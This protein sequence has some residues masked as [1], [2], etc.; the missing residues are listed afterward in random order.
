MIV[1]KFGGTSIKNKDAI[2]NIPSIVKSRG[3]GQLVVV[4]ALRG[5][6][7]LLISLA[8]KLKLNLNSDIY[9]EVA[10]FHNV[11]LELVS[12]I[13][14]DLSIASELKKSL[15]DLIEAIIQIGHLSEN[16]FNRLL[17]QGELASSIILNKFLE[18]HG[19][20]S[21]IVEIDDLLEFEN[22]SYR[23][24]NEISSNRI[25]ITQ[26][27]F[28]KKENEII[29][30]GRGGSD[31]SASIFGS[32]LNAQEIQIWTDVDGLMSADPRI[33]KDARVID[34]ISFENMNDMARYGAKVLH[35][36]TIKPAIKS[37]I[38]VRILNTF[39]PENSGT[40]I[41]NELEEN[42][43]R[44]V[45]LKQDLLLC[46]VKN[47]SD[48]NTIEKLSYEINKLSKFNLNVFEFFGNDNSFEALID[49]EINLELIDLFSEAEFEQS[50]VI[51]IIGKNPTK[52]LRILKT[53]PGNFN[54]NY[55]TSNNSTILIIP[56]GDQKKL[57]SLI[58]EIISS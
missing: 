28:A 58:H 21:K 38:P 26:G 5:V 20:E 12:S 37:N 42:D 30:L 24:I 35:P 10:D 33:V 25:T 54:F 18:K 43:I 27:F 2:K 31:L 4:S 53:L 7:D 32:L 13:D 23:L 46:K 48:L 45:V 51:C 3:N 57:L 55:N 52:F 1:L 56:P 39:S 19:I 36:D 8:E 29:N 14:L 34:K 44:A 40:L 41:I 15:I 6:T 17:L 16:S 11:H 22:S 50:N 9:N 47:S 49:D